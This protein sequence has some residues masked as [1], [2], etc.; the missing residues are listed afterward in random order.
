MALYLTNIYETHSCSPDLCGNLL[1]WILAKSDRKCIKE[2][3]VS[4]MLLSEIWLSLHWSYETHSGA[5]AL[6]GDLLCWISPKYVKKC[7]NYG[8]KLIYAV[9]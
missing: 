6:L 1:Y 3:K 4:C 7:G 2:G 5:L 9:K 8:L